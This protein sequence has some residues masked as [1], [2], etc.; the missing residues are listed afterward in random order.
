MRKIFL[1]E[2]DGAL[3]KVYA[4]VNHLFEDKKFYKKREIISGEDFSDVEYIFSTWGMPQFTEEEIKKYLPG[5]KAVFYAAG[6]VQEFAK[7]FINCGIKV[8]SAWQANAVPVAEYT[9]AQ[10]L[11]AGK[12]YFPI[13][14]EQSVGNLEKAKEIN[15]NY[16]GNFNTSVGII[17]VGMI[18]KKVIELLKPYRLD[19]LA[20]DKFLSEEEIEKLGAKKVSLE[21]IFESC[22]V[23]SNHLADNEKTKGMLGYELFSK[24]I[25]YA[26]FINTGRGAQIVEDDLCRVLEEREDVTAL[27]DV[28]YPEPPEEGHLFYKLPNC[29]LTPHIAGSLGKE[30]MRMAE[31]MIEEYDKTIKGEKCS[32]EVTLEMLKTMA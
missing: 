3:K 10:I 22:L 11:L 4:S 31:Y 19:I 17:G 30:L 20:Y 24:F 7:E 2:A 12:G 8:H 15:G 21:E 1:G 27:L 26:S 14:R 32:Y 9:V 29:F 18:G 6:S 25:P 5:L 13:S 16:P 28:T 23:I